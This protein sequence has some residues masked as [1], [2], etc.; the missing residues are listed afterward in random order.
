MRRVLKRQ[1]RRA[2]GLATNDD[3]DRFLTQLRSDADA[4]EAKAVVTLIDSVDECYVQLERDLE[5]RTRSLDI[6]SQ[7]LFEVN[8]RL[9]D[10]LASVRS[11]ER[12]LLEVANG[13]TQ[14][15]GIPPIRTGAAG[16]RTLSTMVATLVRERE[17]ARAAHAASEQRLK[18]ALA[19][20][21]VGLWD[22]DLSSTRIYF[23]EM[24]TRLLGAE[25]AER[26][27]HSDELIALSHPDDVRG[28]QSA[29][30]RNLRGGSPFFSIEHRV[31]HCDGRW[32]WL[33][34]YGNVTH[35]DAAGRARRMMGTFTDVSAR[36]ESERAAADHLRL[37]DTLLETMPLPVVI[38]DTERRVQRVNAAWE[39]M[40]GMSRDHAVGSS[41]SGKLS[42]IPP[43][44]Q[45]RTD[46]LVFAHGLPV[47]YETTVQSVK[48][49]QYEC[50]IAKT[51]L[52]NA[53]GEISGLASVITD[54]S[55]QKRTAEALER[56]RFVAESAAEAKSRFL[57][58]MSH[59][60][61]TPL[62][63]VVGMA[64]LLETLELGEKPRRF[65]RTL[66]QS[67]D[68]LIGIV[69]DVLDLSKIEAGKVEMTLGDVNLR[70]EVE[71]VVALFG[72][73]AYDKGI[74]IA[75]HIAQD[76]PATLRCDG[77]RLRQVLSNLIG[78]AVKF[79]ERGA[80][81]V[82]VRGC[83][84]NGAPRIAF[85]VSDTGVGIRHDQ[86]ARVFEAFEQ[87]D[88]GVTRKFGGTGLGLAISKQL[89]ELLGGRIALDSEPGRG[90]RF[91]FSLPCDGHATPG[92]PPD[93]ALAGVIVGTHPIVRGSIAEALGSEASQVFA[94]ET[95]T[96][97]MDAMKQLGPAVRRVRVVVDV[98]E[99]KSDWRA[100]ILALRIAAGPRKLACLPLVAPDA[101]ALQLESV[102]RTL[103]K[104][105]CTS[106]V[107]EAAGT[108]ATTT[109]RAPLIPMEG[110]RGHVLVVEDNA[111][112]QELARAMLE[113]MGFR[114]TLA[115][116]GRE[117]VAAAVEHDDLVAI[118]MD[119]QMPV[120][121]GLAAARAIRANESGGRR[122]P[123]IALTG[124]VM[125]GDR[126]ACVAA[127]MDDY[128]SK[129]I[130]LAALKGALE[131][132]LLTAAPHAPSSAA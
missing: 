89:V 120:M 25:E 116:N 22:W 39:K 95:I 42:V 64:S 27:W 60:L 118:L 40:I 10:E 44:D 127:G 85:A 63:G 17:E 114:V 67:A 129:P 130:G 76:V 91:H 58:N 109:Q 97:A 94:C 21:K 50:T 74:D 8:G 43:Q 111:V 57:A 117:G 47:T 115:A 19:A 56:A 5:L 12:E 37:L 49:E 20:S 99:A 69:N 59:E 33:Q 29:L 55:A 93:A 26:R 121:D 14:G 98:A 106:D 41:L 105:L 72:A 79:T 24:L 102:V 52:R 53:D 77:V 70:R 82:A 101:D 119:C 107:L 35:R 73:R 78:N 48:G 3:V 61:R 88:V 123:I 32:I 81:L 45:Q 66:K 112:N 87:A 28:F 131:R 80:V 46:D 16:L 110:A 68:A 31:R 62:N 11:A 108:G 75:A 30:R 1:L 65:V 83:H 34:T 7:E 9:R 54:I 18:L 4:V 100:A 13:L 86:Q 84:E 23:D 124:N 71:Q 96:E 15:M 92:A 103:Y 113:T 132:Q 6:S 2:F 90:S 38:R 122:V 51:P 125:P 36:K 128:L 126:E 104:P